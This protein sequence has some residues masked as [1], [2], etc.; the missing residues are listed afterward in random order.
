[1]MSQGNDKIRDYSSL[2]SG[3]ATRR[4]VPTA[5]SALGRAGP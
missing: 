5:L 1:M 4:P 3:S 2:D